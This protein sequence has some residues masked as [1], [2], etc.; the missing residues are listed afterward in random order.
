MAVKKNKEYYCE[1]D[2]K[3]SLDGIEAKDS[4]DLIRIVQ[5]LYKQ[6]HDLDIEPSEISHIREVQDEV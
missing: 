4:F 6:A 1:V 2:L 3:F 5:E